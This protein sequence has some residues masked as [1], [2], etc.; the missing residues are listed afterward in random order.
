[1][2][3][4]E[5]ARKAY[6]LRDRVSGHERFRIAGSYYLNGT[7]QLDEA[8]RAYDLWARDYPR[9]SPPF[10]NQGFC[11]N[12][13]GQLDDALR[14]ADAGYQLEPASSALTGTL[15]QIQLALDHPEEV[16]KIASAALQ[17]TPDAFV[18]RLPSLSFC[19]LAYS[20]TR[21]RPSDMMRPSFHIFRLVGKTEE[22]RLKFEMYDEATQQC[23]A[24]FFAYAEP[25]VGG[26]L[27]RHH[28]YR[29]RMSNN[30]KYP[31][32]LAVLAEIP[33]PTK[34]KT[35]TS[36]KVVSISAAAKP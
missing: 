34:Q 33:L 2:S 27:H 10:N 21:F 11:Y 35:L 22:N 8:I 14:K 16:R 18:I 17:Y 19:V 9:E 3:C 28:A 6:E 4:T 29:V 12:M 36:A 32:I 25:S 30:P 7:G 26:E 1:M 20:V 15:A 23:G 24:K 31:Q 5:A 13:L